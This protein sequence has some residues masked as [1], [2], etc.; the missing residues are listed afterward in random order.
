MTQIR[1]RGPRRGAQFKG[2][3]KRFALGED[4]TKLPFGE[5]G[6]L[7]Y[8]TIEAAGLTGDAKRLAQE[9][10]KVHAAFLQILDVLSYPTD[11]DGHVHDLSALGPTKNAIAWTLALCG[12]RF[13]GRRYI[14]KRFIHAP[15]VPVGAHTWVDVRLPDDA[16]E[17]LAPEHRSTDYTLP[18]DTRRLAA[19]RDG[20]PPQSMPDGWHVTPTI[21]EEFVERKERP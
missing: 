8:K 10:V 17:E 13:T 9:M 19:L 11:P 3:T 14:K 2:N 1:D 21:T 20:D 15:G 5:H 4:G 18:P 6:E 12:C 16:A 7:T